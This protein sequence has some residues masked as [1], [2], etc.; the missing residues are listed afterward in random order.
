MSTPAS[1]I[2][3][4]LHELD[5]EEVSDNTA[6]EE[7]GDASEE[8]EIETLLSKE[9]EKSD[10]EESLV[11]LVA[12][13]HK[14]KQSEAGKNDLYDVML[15][16]APV[17]AGQ[18][19]TEDTEDGDD[20]SVEPSK[21]F[22]KWKD[23]YKIYT[24]RESREKGSARWVNP[25]KSEEERQKWK[26]QYLPKPVYTPLYQQDSA[27]DSRQQGERSKG[28]GRNKG[29]HRKGK[30]KGKGR[31]G[32]NRN[33]NKNK[34]KDI[35]KISVG[36]QSDSVPK[37]NDVVMAHTSSKMNPVLPTESGMSR[38]HT[39]DMLHCKGGGRCV[40]DKMRGGVRCQCKL[41][42]DGEFC[43]NGKFQIL[44]FSMED[45]ARLQL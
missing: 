28:K 8:D 2:P 21:R 10:I 12:D 17:E 33:K 3:P 6:A 24:S 42:T 44:F 14:S 34:M 7:D 31:K 16:D 27:G 43:E 32:K 45:K 5:S 35:T 19:D 41:G 1:T 36:T 37:G 29:G 38:F 18:D 20:P 25:F 13:H 11:S 26:A 40:P 39:C 9:P 4:E 23:P 15:G 30:G 22:Y